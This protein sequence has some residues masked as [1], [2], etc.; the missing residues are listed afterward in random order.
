MA[1]VMSRT[2]DLLLPSRISISSPFASV[3]LSSRQ[4]LEL[5]WREK[6]LGRKISVDFVRN[7]TDQLYGVARVNAVYETRKY[8]HADDQEMI[9]EFVRS[10]SL[11]VRC[12]VYFHTNVGEY[13][14]LPDGALGVPHPCWQLLSL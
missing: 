14:H 3:Q 1:L 12:C 7:R 13:D 4:R 8:M 9:T 2:P 6:D 5:Y 11:L 10:I